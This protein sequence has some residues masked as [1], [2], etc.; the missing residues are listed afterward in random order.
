MMVL[1]V[2]GGLVHCAW[3]ADEPPVVVVRGEF[4]D[5]REDVDQFHSRVK[6]CLQ[7]AGIP[8]AEL[9]DSDV[10]A[11]KL[12]GY[13]L[14]IF[15]YN[16]TVTDRELTEIE[17]FVAGGGKLFVFYSLPERVAK[18][19]G[20]ENVGH[21]REE[22]EGQFA[23]LRF[24]SRAIQGL[25]RSARQN[26]WNIHQV[27]PA[28][29]D[30]K[31]IAK[32]I[33]GKGKDTGYVGLTAS[34][35]GFYLSHVLL[36]GD[37]DAKQ[38]MFL[39]LIG[40]LFPEVWAEAVAKVIAQIGQV[41]TFTDL[42]QLG[43]AIQAAQQKGLDTRPA[44]RDW[45]RARQLR[46]KA[47]ALARR[48]Q[49][50]LAIPVA[51][52]AQQY[53]R[54]AYYP[55]QASRASEFRAVWIH[56]AYGVRDWGWEKSIRVLKEQGFNAII[57]NMLWAGLAHYD[58]EVLPVAE[59]VKQRGD[60]IAECLKWCQKY[61][62]ELH[63]WKVNYNLSTAPQEFIA[64]LRAEGRTQKNANGED[65]NWLCPSHP[66]NFALERDSM[67]E[68]VRKYAVDG[69]HFDYIRYPDGDACYCDGC[70]ERFEKAAGVTVAH[71]PEDVRQGELTERFGDWRRDQIT[72]LVEAVS[73]E[74][75]RLRPGLKIS[76]AVFSNWKAHRVSVGQ[77]WKLWI[78]KG[79]LDF[80]CPMDYTTSMN[81]L[82]QLTRWQVEWVDGRVPLYTGLGAWRLASPDR[83]IDQIQ[84]ARQLGAD[85]FVL[86]HY[87]DLNFAQ[88]FLPA[89]RAG[90]T[91]VD[92]FA[93]HQPSPILFDLPRGRR[94]FEEHRYPEG[95]EIPVTIRFQPWAAGDPPI[96][97]MRASL[98]LR[99]VEGD[100]VQ[101][102]GT[103]AYTE[104]RAHQVVLKL[105]EGRY[106]LFVEGTVRREGVLR[107]QP[108]SA[109]SRIIHVLSA[110]ALEA[111]RAKDAPPR[112]EGE[113]LRVGI[114]QDGY[115][116]EGLY[117]ALK[118][119]KGL[120]P[121]YVR[122][123]KKE[124][125]DVCQVLILAQPRT[126]GDLAGPWR[127]NV[128]AW[129][130]G[131][132]GLLATHDAVGYRLLPAVIPEVC[133]R[134]VSLP[135]ETKWQVVQEHPV[136]AGLKAGETFEHSYYDHLVLVPG[137]QGQ[138]LAGRAGPGAAEPV[139]LAG[140]FGQGRYV[141]NGMAVGL[142]PDDTD[143]EPQGAELTLLVNAVKW[144]GKV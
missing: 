57:P 90:V 104:P 97:L 124:T 88:E 17:K 4:T 45:Q 28:G 110:A 15:S 26:S 42:E 128:R 134:G 52:K 38:Q 139:L 50:A 62:I 67:L 78:E 91:S 89:L 100:D 103:L 22:Y 61:G 93:P 114:F 23:T 60:Q 84:L 74:A 92:A 83:L 129:V 24:S 81:Q 36:E 68:V 121:F 6:D 40:H 49:F 33:D 141:A 11:G 25:P 131:G 119:V 76:A 32:W 14:A 64:R 53:A 73:T 101:P 27:R 132:G 70:R 105:R 72:R 138:A 102:L 80:V 135:R 125:L 82:D 127:E 55:L 130:Q 29:P 13:R 7:G 35:N 59:P 106:R 142:N 79:Y 10:E 133:Q 44:I 112:V 65:V 51:K 86:F 20:L 140:E 58:S 34:P 30:T 116:S 122:N 18:L 98:E 8:F 117:A 126:P 113:G 1:V 94:E 9:N 109:R 41:S 21:L 99:A 47:Q 123:L 107:P 95:A 63:V 71:W 31:V 85:G 48:E 46:E 143:G 19:L 136:T 43:E 37:L 108:F 69:I 16:A 96:Q 115:G 120:L 137:E 12:A 75:R 77:D 144:L 54:R 118:R 5:E 66:A 39:A 2:V 87:D 111:E 56:T 3:G